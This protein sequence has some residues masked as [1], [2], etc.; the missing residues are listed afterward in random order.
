M[1]ILGYKKLCLCLHLFKNPFN[2]P[3][4]IIYSSYLFAYAVYPV[5]GLEWLYEHVLELTGLVIIAHPGSITALCNE[6]IIYF[7]QQ[8]QVRKRFSYVRERNTI[9]PTA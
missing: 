6:G 7:F 4:Y 5:W 8:S 3:F 9:L 1:I 2:V